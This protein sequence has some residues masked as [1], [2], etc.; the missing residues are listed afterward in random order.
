ML[1]QQVYFQTLP[2]L[3]IL[4][5]PEVQAIVRNAEQ[6]LELHERIAERIDQVER[7]LSWRRDDGLRVEDG[8]QQARKTRVAAARIAGVLAEQVRSLSL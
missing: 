2:F 6:L 4:T 5:L 1:S 8:P 7:E 3:T